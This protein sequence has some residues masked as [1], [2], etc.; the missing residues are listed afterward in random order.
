M[1]RRPSRQP[2]MQMKTATTMAAAASARIAERHADQPDQHRGDDHMSERKCSAS[3]SSASLE[4][5]LGDAIEHARAEE[6]DHDRT[7]R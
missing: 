5:S 6:I 2:A 1:V 3:A 4:V 7:Q